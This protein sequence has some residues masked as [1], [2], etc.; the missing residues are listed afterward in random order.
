MIFKIDLDRGVHSRTAPDN[1][2]MEIYMYVDT[3]GVYLSAHG[4]E[5]PIALAE[6]AGFPVAE[7]MKKRRL[8]EA[9][10]AARNEVL[11]KMQEADGREKVVTRDKEG[12]KIVDIGMDRYVVYSP[13]DDRLTPEPLSLMHANILLDQLV[14]DQEEEDAEPPAKV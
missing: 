9:L 4:T 14:P 1:G 11:A 12:F 13:D 5:V 7:H 3:P 10:E 8:K 2:G 6:A